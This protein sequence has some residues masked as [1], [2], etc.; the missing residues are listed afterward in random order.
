MATYTQ[1]NRP[2]RAMTPLGEDE[3]LLAGFTGEETVSRLFT[4]HLDLLS[5]NGAIEAQEL[6]G[7]PIT[8]SVQLGDGSVRY[9][10]GI[11]SRFGAGGRDDDLFHYRAEVVPQLWV[12]TRRMNSRI[13]QE[14]TVLEI[15]EKVFKD[16]GLSEFRID[17][18]GQLVKREFCVQ[19]RETD[20][21]FVSRLLED[22]GIYYFFEHEGDKHTMV[23]ANTP[24]SHPPVPGPATIDFE[25]QQQV[26]EDVI[27]EWTKVQELRSGKYTLWDY[28]FEKPDSHLDATVA[29]D[30]DLELYEFPGGHQKREDGEAY[31]RVRLEAEE[32]LRETLRGAGTC[33]QMVA[34]HKFTLARH[35]SSDGEYVLTSVSHAAQT[36]DY[37][38]E[39]GG[40]LDYRVDFT[41]IPI[42]VPF[43]PQ[44]V[45][46]KPVIRG[47]QTALVVGKKGEEIWVDKYGRVKVQFH[48]DREGKKDENSSCWIRVAMPWAGKGW[49]SV[50]LPR[51][52]N[53]VVV[54]FLEGDPDRPIIVGSVY[55]ANQTVPFDLPGSGIQMGMKS[56]SSPGGGGHN[57]VTLTDTKGKEKITIHGQYDMST[58]VLHDDTQTVKND[59]TI[60]VDGKHTE[61]IKKDTSI[62]VTEGNL[63]LTIADGTATVTVKKAVTENFDATQATTAKK[64]ISITSA[65]ADI[66]LTASTEIKLV[67]GDSSLVLK[68]DGTIK[69]IGK[70][71]QIQGDDEVKVGGK[72]IEV[73]AGDEAKLGVGNQNVTCDKTKVGVSGAAINSSAVGMHEITGAVVKIN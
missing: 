3:L 2:M 48:W 41:A 10:N 32:V 63:T 54:S 16:G 29:G 64:K 23:L 49:G 22:E 7:Q 21:D 11:V 24:N 17:C 51:I 69:L 6:L 58:T 25:P 30:N 72:K 35:F 38:S 68:K 37:R 52:G 56:R 53:E 59:R 39:R 13:F 40:S 33:R 15:V 55:N 8:V 46:Q 31:A 4:F 14:M 42:G 43:R 28:C 57:E 18:I 44:R 27:G 20:F 45:T 60:T 5:E 19:Y 66:V 9:I 61:T 70:K 50:S 12:L 34:G 65:E 67:S 71:V 62:T 26:D 73:S 47:T 36:G 1:V